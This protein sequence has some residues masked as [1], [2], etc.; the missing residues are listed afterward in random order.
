[1]APVSVL[2]LSP[3]AAGRGEAA[4]VRESLALVEAAERLGYHR[5][6]FAEHHG[7]AML[8]SSSP[9]LMIAAAGARTERIRLGA[10]GIMLPNHTPLHVAE[11]F[12]VLEAL[13]PGRIDLGIGRAP[14]TDYVTAMALRGGRGPGGGDLER[15]L[16]ELLA[17]SGL[18]RWPEGHHF[19]SVAAAPRD[20]PLPPI[21]LLGSSDYSAKVAAAAGLGF[22]FAAQ[23]NPVEAVATLRAYRDRFRPSERL[24]EPLAIL[25]HNV[26]CAE[27]IERAAELAAPARVAF[28]R[29]RAGAPGPLPPPEEAIGSDRAP[30][31][32]AEGIEGLRVVIG[33][34][35]FVTETLEELRS[36][37]G[38]DELM[39]M[40][41]TYELADRIRSYELIARSLDLVT[42]AGERAAAATG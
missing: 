3:V 40:A 23:I 37:S 28:R 20:A 14:G 31:I 34:P 29:L 25:S 1:M 16:A 19:A 21:I 2:D 42:T 35:G 22:A 8:A 6:W 15:M 18:Q 9:E 11:Q 10:G 30:R 26:V 32:P 41:S 17:F 4:A 24:G 36:R 33:D 7:G 12:K 38:A 5:Y 39:L 13:Y 27:T